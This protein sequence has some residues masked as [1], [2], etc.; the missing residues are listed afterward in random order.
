VSLLYLALVSIYALVITA[1]GG[2]QAARLHRRLMAGLGPTY[3][4][5]QIE[6]ISVLVVLFFICIV[7]GNP[8]GGTMDP[9][10]RF[11]VVATTGALGSVL[12]VTLKLRDIAELNP[13]R[14]VAATTWIQPLIGASIGLISWRILASGA[15]SIGGID[16]QAW[17]TQALV[18]FASGLS[19][20][21]PPF[22][23]FTGSSAALSTA[24]LS[25]SGSRS[26]QPS[27]RTSHHSPTLTRGHQP[28]K[29]PHGWSSAPGLEIRTGGRWSGPT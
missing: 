17:Q 25:G 12:A 10:A 6:L 11:V 1:A 27:T 16:N 23:K 15:V 18:A 28:L 14:G 4:A 3:L 5:Y 13:F 8:D 26:T 9:W 20:Q 21:T 7:A 19:E 24:E 29:R 22:A 2:E